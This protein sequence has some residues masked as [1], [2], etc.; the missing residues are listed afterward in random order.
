ML[1]LVCL[2]HMKAEAAVR[3]DG[4]EGRALLGSGLWMVMGV[5]GCFLLEFSAP[6]TIHGESTFLLLL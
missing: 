2:S 5:Y 6:L 3:V 4:E 1:S